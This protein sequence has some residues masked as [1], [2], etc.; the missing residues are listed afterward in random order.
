ME[1]R[2]SIVIDPETGTMDLI[3]CGEKK[4]TGNVLTVTNFLT[5]TEGKQVKSLS[6]EDQKQLV[7]FLLS[8]IL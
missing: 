7:K 1:N 6:V 8:N 5:D 2:L 3:L 4:S